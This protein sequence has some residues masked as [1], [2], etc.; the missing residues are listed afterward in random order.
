VTAVT[1]SQAEMRETTRALDTGASRLPV[2]AEVGRSSDDRACP[3]QDAHLN[4]KRDDR[5]RRSSN[6]YRSEID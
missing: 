3:R 5:L 4:R 1:A 6:L 2:V